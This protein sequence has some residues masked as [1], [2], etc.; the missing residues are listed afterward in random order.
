MIEWVPEGQI[1]Y[2]KYYTEVLIQLRERGRKKSGF[3]DAQLLD[4]VPGQRANPQS[5]PAK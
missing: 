2:Q 3:I 1:G 4:S 5:L